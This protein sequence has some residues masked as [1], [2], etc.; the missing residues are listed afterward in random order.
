MINL[1]HDFKT[2]QKC[3]S[4]FY[5][6][7]KQV[8]NLTKFILFSLYSSYFRTCLGLHAFLDHEK[9]K[10]SKQRLFSVAQVEQ[11]QGDSFNFRIGNSE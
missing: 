3:K 5:A 7:P 6:E 10:A 4:Q 2:K 11:V 9:F 8:N 1:L